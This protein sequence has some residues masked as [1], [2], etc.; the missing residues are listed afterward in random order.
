MRTVARACI[1]LSMRSLAINKNIRRN[2]FIGT[3][4]RVRTASLFHIASTRFS[5][6]Q[7]RC[8][9]HIITYLLIQM[10]GCPINVDGANAIDIHRM[11]ASVVLNIAAIA[12]IYSANIGISDL[13]QTFFRKIAA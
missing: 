4:P 13:R 1:S 6:S 11:R 3:G 8:R 7:S 12:K 10:D 9:R 2:D 5:I